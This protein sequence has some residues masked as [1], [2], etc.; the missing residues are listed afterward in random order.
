MPEVFVVM[1]ATGEYS[2]RYEWPVRAFLDE[3]KA[4]A[5]VAA[6]DE[7]ARAWLARS[8]DHWQQYMNFR[9]LSETEKA[10]LFPHDPHFSMDYTGTS[11]Y[12]MKVELEPPFSGDPGLPA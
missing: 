3:G 4:Q 11:Y 5:L 2:D 6:A 8:A 9:E 1:G 12:V 7:D 10:E